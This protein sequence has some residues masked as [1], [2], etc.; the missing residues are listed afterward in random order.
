MESANAAQGLHGVSSLFLSR[1][2]KERRSSS[3][4]G[5]GDS[6]TVCLHVS[7]GSD[8]IGGALLAW[9]LAVE[10]ARKGLR[11]AVVEGDPDLPILKILAG[12]ARQEGRTDGSL[13]P[14]TCSRVPI[15]GVTDSNER[16]AGRFE[17]LVIHGP[18]SAL[19]SEAEKGA[20]A[21]L[22]LVLSPTIPDRVSAYR[23]VERSALCHRGL[24]LMLILSGDISR[25][26]AGSFLDP[27][28][29]LVAKQFG[30]ESV[31]CGRLPDWETLCNSKADSPIDGGEMRDRFRRTVILASE[32]LGVEISVRDS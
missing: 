12:A 6:A 15:L 13:L 18:M 30:V 2:S 7:Y 25:D 28:R 26:H 20:I 8:A 17:R 11:T 5:Q 27:L 4:Q 29:E 9:N 22:L 14:A 10:S 32:I 3:T 1:P 24:R 23:L 19:R 31:Y 21:S 16:A